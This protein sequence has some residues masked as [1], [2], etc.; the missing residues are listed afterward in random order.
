[1]A[2]PDIGSL[3]LG[4]P[5]AMFSTPCSATS[6]S[7]LE[8]V[9]CDDA[10]A[11]GRFVRL[12]SPLVYGWA[13]KAGLQSED[14]ADVAQDVFLA[15]S[16]HLG[17]FSKSAPG[18]TFRGWLWTIARNQIRLFYRRRKLRPQ[19]LPAQDCAPAAVS[20]PSWL[21]D[22]AAPASPGDESHLVRRA[23]ELIQGDFQ[24]RTWRAF[25]L[26][27]VEGRSAAE[28]GEE[29]QMTPVAVR[30]AKYRVLSRLQA[31]LRPPDS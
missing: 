17:G 9:R 21:D 26:V 22:E 30:Q 1:M 10:E 20:P 23:L 3:A 4:A 12:Y 15:V 18:A 24:E 28:A 16:L 19:G 11:W 2:A 29:L 7:L 13:R 8:R 27:A 14:A 5:D 25:W 6:L 31:E